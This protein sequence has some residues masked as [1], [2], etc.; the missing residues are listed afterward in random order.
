VFIVSNLDLLPAAT[1]RAYLAIGN[2]DGV[3][4]GHQALLNRLR[5]RA[6]AAGA[7]AI[8]LSFE[9]RPVELLRPDSAP[10][11]LTWPERKVELLLQAGA[12]DVGFFQTGPWLLGLTAREFFD[13]VIL[14]LFHA[15]GLVEGP[16]FAFGRD[17]DGDTK[18]LGEWC[19]HSGLEFEVVEP[20]ELDAGLITTTR[21]RQALQHGDAAS[22]A[23]W[24]GRPHR[25]IGQV[26]RGQGRGAGFGFPTANLDGIRGLVPGHGV[27]A[28]WATAAGLAEQRPAAVHIGPN[29]TLGAT[30]VT[31][32]AHLLDFSG[33]LY[34]QVLNLDFTAQIRGTRKFDGIPALLAQIAR[35]VQETRDS[36]NLDH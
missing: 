29:S 3:H 7:R 10:V 35:D 28:A 31:V 13:R 8:A 25:I 19:R 23:R 30:A 22:A 9:P 33:D 17:R 32:E 20:L 16:T 36:L 21:I 2:F 5:R 11:P 14:G 12:H 24:L 4:K 18:L 15:R 34:G 26:V 6:D 1:R 27:Y